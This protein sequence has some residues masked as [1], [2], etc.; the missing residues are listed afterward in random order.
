MVYYRQEETNERGERNEIHR[1]NVGNLQRETG[2]AMLRFAAGNVGVL[3]RIGME[4]GKGIRP[5]ATK[6]DIKMKGR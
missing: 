6:S 1:T 4:T 2:S 5:G 3:D